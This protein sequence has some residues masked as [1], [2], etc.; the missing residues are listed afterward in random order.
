MNCMRFPASCCLQNGISGAIRSG[1]YC[2]IEGEPMHRFQY[3][4]SK[5]VFLAPMEE[6]V[7]LHI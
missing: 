7:C 1:L 5:V 6:N 3:G 4:V 2:F